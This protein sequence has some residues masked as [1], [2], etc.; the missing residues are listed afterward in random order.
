MITIIYPRSIVITK[1]NDITPRAIKLKELL[2]K[3]KHPATVN[4][5]YQ[6]EMSVWLLSGAAWQGERYDK[7]TYDNLKDAKNA[8][9]IIQD[10][11]SNQKREPGFA[12]VSEEEEEFWVETYRSDNFEMFWSVGDIT[13]ITKK[14]LTTSKVMR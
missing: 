12:Q 11:I 7:L 10:F 13:K 14:I 6:L 5:S 3:T 2:T 4:P 8:R 9:K 1:E